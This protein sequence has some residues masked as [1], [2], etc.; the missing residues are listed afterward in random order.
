METIWQFDVYLR[1]KK[2]GKWEYYSFIEGTQDEIKEYVDDCLRENE[3]D[4]TITNNSY[5]TKT[6]TF[7]K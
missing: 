1:N 3:T 5:I 7:E 6:Y 4:V 2:T